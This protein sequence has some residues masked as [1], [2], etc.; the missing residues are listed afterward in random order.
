MHA[1]GR[2]RDEQA[3][4]VSYIIDF[5]QALLDADASKPLP[6]AHEMALQSERCMGELQR[7][8]RYCMISH[9]R[10]AEIPSRFVRYWSAVVDHSGPQRLQVLVLLYG[11]DAMKSV[12][13][14]SSDSLFI[15]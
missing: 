6:P 11:T 5:M 15:F 13:R 4:L 7:R 3:H 9:I 14:M 1:A 10:S 12:D 2:H 8:G